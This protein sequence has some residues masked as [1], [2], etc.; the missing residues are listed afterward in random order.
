[1]AFS[2]SGSSDC[3]FLRNIFWSRRLRETWGEW[4]GIRWLYDTL[5][6][7]C[8]LG[9][10]MCIRAMHIER[11]RLWLLS[12]EIKIVCV[13]VWC[14]LAHTHREI[15]SICDAL[16]L[17]PCTRTLCYYVRSLQQSVYMWPINC[18]TDTFSHTLDLALYT[19]TQTHKRLATPSDAP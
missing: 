17:S 3:E 15:Y 16:L 12:V 4:K 11:H 13:C 1:M 7:L 14:E 18:R 10:Y 8:A 19:N 2:H 5:K 6:M 9:T